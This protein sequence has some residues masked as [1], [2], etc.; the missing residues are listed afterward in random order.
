M[1]QD[2]QELLLLAILFGWNCAAATVYRGHGV[3]ASQF[4]SDATADGRRV[5]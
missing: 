3:I 2:A 5:F 4:R 1:D